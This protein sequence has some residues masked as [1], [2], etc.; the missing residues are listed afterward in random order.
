MPQLVQALQDGT[1]DAVVI[2]RGQ[3]AQLTGK[4]FSLLLDMYPANILGVQNVLV[5]PL[6]NT[7]MRSRRSWPG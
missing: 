2:D 1:I 7:R 6:V 4:G 5:V 3:S